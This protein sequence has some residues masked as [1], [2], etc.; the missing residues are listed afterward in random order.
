EW[1]AERTGS[2]E[3]RIA[4]PGRRTFELA[5]NAARAALD[6]AGVAA[7]D[8]D[9]ILVAT[10][11][12]DGPF[13]SVACR[14]QADLGIPGCCAMD[15]LA[16]CSG[17]AYGLSLADAYIASGRVDTILVVGAEVLSRLRERR[18]PRAGVPFF[19]G[20]G[21]AVRRPAQRGRR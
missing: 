4:E 15:I 6:D 14:V 9:M 21:G 5:T 12:P 17:F 7:G 8:L 10:S 18:G 16:A 19:D 13:P 2:K 1:I 20:P 11:S 3:R